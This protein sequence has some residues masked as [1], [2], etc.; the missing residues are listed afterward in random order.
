MFI[1]YCNI[2]EYK[3][4]K[5]Q[6]LLY[7]QR[8]QQKSNSRRVDATAERQSE[9]RCSGQGE[10][11]GQRWWKG[12]QRC[13]VGLKSVCLT[14]SSDCWR[15]TVR[16]EPANA[17]STQGQ[18]PALERQMWRT[19]DSW[20]PTCRGQTFGQRCDVWPWLTW[21]E[22]AKPVLRLEQIQEDAGHFY[23]FRHACATCLRCWITSAVPQYQGKSCSR[24]YREV[25]PFSK[26]Q[27]SPVMGVW[28]ERLQKFRS[29]LWGVSRASLRAVCCPSGAQ[30]GVLPF[31]CPTSSFPSHDGD[32]VRSE[33]GGS[34][35][36]HTP[37]PASWIP[38]SILPWTLKGAVAMTAM[39]PPVQF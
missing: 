19:T 23:A 20:G 31:L 16:P 35:L 3:P 29:T 17:A 6:F 10:F 9:H 32:G 33:E 21:Q 36:P 34:E 14:G 1:S 26:S 18:K 38:G 39:A 28:V 11:K 24:T 13:L 12:H 8:I 4:A 37:A 25:C 27:D 2:S 22:G 30:T 5:H 15:P 7:K